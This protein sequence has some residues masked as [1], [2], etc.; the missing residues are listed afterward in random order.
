MSVPQEPPPSYEQ[1]TAT[2]TSSSQTSHAT[3]TTAATPRC[4]S[5]DSSSPQ[6]RP[7]PEGWIRTFDRQTQHPFYVDTKA[8]PPRSTW[9][10]PYDDAQYLDSLPPSERQRI[11]SSRPNPQA[12][13]EVPGGGGYLTA[14][15]TDEEAFHSDD[16]AYRRQG[17]SSQREKRRLGRKFKDKITG[18]THEQRAAERR[19][20]EQE[21]RD[22]E[23]Q[24]EIFWK[25]MEDAIRS[26]R[27]QYLGKDRQGKDV[28][29]EPPSGAGLG[30]N[31]GGGYPGVISRRRLSP[32][33]SEVEYR[34]GRRPGP[35]G[36]YLRPDGGGLGLGY[37]YGGGYGY[38][39]G[40][41]GVGYRRPVGGG[42]GRGFGGLPLFAPILGGLM[43]G[44]MIS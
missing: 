31:L 38:G 32:Y 11:R 36:R 27:P 1:A 9:N 13:L 25:C 16:P 30:G 5:L 20:R 24:E 19:R 41:G 7:L 40:L 10:H 18:T 37:S 15:S 35:E 3:S 42:Y 28:F 6:L 12:H 22:A 34:I 33:L 43:I 29:L 23:R 21:E 2:A 8:N 17:S 39:T 26:G 4:N 44:S 14:E